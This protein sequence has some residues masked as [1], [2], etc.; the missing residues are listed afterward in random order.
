MRGY[1]GPAALKP[2]KRNAPRAEW[3]VA[4]GFRQ[5]LRT[6]PCA[7][8]GRNPACAG[9]IEA[10][11]VD[12]A[13]TKGMGLKVADADCIPLSQACHRHQHSIGWRTFE[14]AYLPGPA[15]ELANEYWQAWPGRIEWQRNLEK[16]HA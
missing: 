1:L 7:C 2:R 5:W 12:H 9:K 4:E 3:R 8:A 14:G 10:A 15:P 16:S 11:H 13:G 6:R